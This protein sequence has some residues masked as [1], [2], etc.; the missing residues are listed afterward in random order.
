MSGPVHIEVVPAADRLRALCFMVA[1][2]RGDE[3]AL[4][5]GQAFATMVEQAGEKARLWWAMGKRQVLAVAM[6]LDRPGQAGMLFYSPPSASGVKTDALIELIAGITRE[7]IARGDAFVQ[8]TLLPSATRDIRILA[9]AGM[10]HLADL[11]DMRLDFDLSSPAPEACPSPWQWRDHDHFTRRQLGQVILASYEQSLDCPLLKGLRTS[12]Q[13]IA[14]HRATGVF[15][16]TTWYLAGAADGTP[17]GCVL[18]ND[19]TAERA[20]SIVYLGVV[21]EF[22]RQGLATAMVTHA[23][24]IARSRHQ[25]A[26][27]LAVDTRNTHARQAYLQAGFVQTVGRCVY[28]AHKGQKQP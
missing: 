22:R 11:A 16:P 9:D 14:G 3:E 18:M 20:A 28:I 12:A 19:V 26:L 4:A 10:A 2:K 27:T 7:S 21:P 23:Q 17:A 1:G 8:A 15:S 25:L 6:V 13:V 5:R 24:A